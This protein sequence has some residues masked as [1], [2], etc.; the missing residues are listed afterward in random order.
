MCFRKTNA[1]FFK[2]INLNKWEAIESID[3]RGSMKSRWSWT[4]RN[5]SRP[6]KYTWDEWEQAD[7]S[8]SMKWDDV[9]WMKH[10]L[11]EPHEII[12]TIYR[13]AAGQKIFPTK[14]TEL[15]P[16]GTQWMDQKETKTVRNSMKRTQIC[17][18]IDENRNTMSFTEIDQRNTHSP[19]YYLTGFCCSFTRFPSF[20]LI[21]LLLAVIWFML[22]RFHWYAS[23]VYAPY[24][25]HFWCDSSMRYV[26]LSWANYHIL[27]HCRSL[28]TIRFGSAD[29]KKTK[30]KT[31]VFNKEWIC[32]WNV[33]MFHLSNTIECR[34]Q[35]NE[36]EP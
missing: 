9:Q 17:R 18:M 8:Q 19:H 23:E 26:W 6:F 29:W 13:L 31:Y 14:L 5:W 15:T 22:Q 35:S 20:A 16:P 36:Y 4:K 1:L 2:A 28:H 32:I 21:H 7:E 33:L 30:H 3:F 25:E 34:A 10:S 11:I 12:T 27:P 24:V